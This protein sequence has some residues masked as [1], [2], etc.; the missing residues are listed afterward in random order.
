MV[1]RF[2]V[3]NKLKI[4]LIK[5]YLS[6]LAF[7]FFFFYC[8]CCVFWGIWVVNLGIPGV[9]LVWRIHWDL[10]VRVSFQLLLG[11][12]SCWIMLEVSFIIFYLL[13]FLFIFFFFVV[14]FIFLPLSKW[15]FFNAILDYY[16]K[17]FKI[18][19]FILF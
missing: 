1:M 4:W 6:E 3:R 2:V 10:A 12:L 5:L 8:T 16:K 13:F 7:F 17:K 18:L 14:A 15:L 11:C 19:L 9:R